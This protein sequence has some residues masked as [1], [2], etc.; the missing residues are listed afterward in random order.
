MD[1]VK[2]NW[3]NTVRDI[4]DVS[5]HCQPGIRIGRI[6]EESWNPDH[7]HIFVTAKELVQDGGPEGAPSNTL[8]AVMHEVNESD[9]QIRQSTPSPECPIY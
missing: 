8:L 7:V 5:H 1:D 9:A 2:R 4:E 6:F 3:I